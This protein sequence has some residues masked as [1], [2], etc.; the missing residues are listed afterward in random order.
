MSWDCTF[1]NY[2]RA[3]D[4][5]VQW[6]HRT[7]AWGQERGPEVAEERSQQFPGI[8]ENV[9][10]YLAKTSIRIWCNPTSFY[11]SKL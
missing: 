10:I 4:M 11:I 1:S 7:S 5:G 2:T 9:C 8:P 3:H 6:A